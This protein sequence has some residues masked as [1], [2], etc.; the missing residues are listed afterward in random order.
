MTETGGITCTSCANLDMQRYPEAAKNGWAVC[1]VYPAPTFVRVQMI[2]NCDKYQEAPED[3]AKARESWL[4][5][6]TVPM[7][8]R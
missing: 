7:W 2:R 8:Q 4:N 3:Q 5:K 6:N 1:R